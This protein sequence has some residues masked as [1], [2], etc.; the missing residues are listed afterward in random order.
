MTKKEYIERYDEFVKLIQ[1][2]AGQISYAET[3]AANLGLFK[4]ELLREQS[5]LMSARNNLEIKRNKHLEDIHSV[6]V[7][8]MH[9]INIK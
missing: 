2:G 6:L 1:E 4:L 8:V 3:I 5:V 7:K 9:G